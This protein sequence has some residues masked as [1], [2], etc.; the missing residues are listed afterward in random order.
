M[1]ENKRIG[2]TKKNWNDR[3]RCGR[4]GTCL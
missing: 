3:N 1:T 2:T 4:R